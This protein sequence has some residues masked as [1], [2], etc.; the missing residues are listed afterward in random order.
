MHNPVQGPPGPNARGA[1]PNTPTSHP[2]SWDAAQQGQPRGMSNMP[3]VPPGSCT[4]EA[5]TKLRDSAVLLRARGRTGIALERFKQ[6]V[7]VQISLLGWQNREV[8]E[9]WENIGIL[10]LLEGMPGEAGEA[11][12]NARASFS[13]CLGAD[14]EEARG[15][16]RRLE[17]CGDPTLQLAAC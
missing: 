6:A 7:A 3:E 9:A 16:Q 4:A 15:V 5:F 17:S 11:F 8:G 13:A 12:S 2:R 14:S 1:A 10:C